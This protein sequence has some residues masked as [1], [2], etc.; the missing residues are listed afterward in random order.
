[1]STASPMAAPTGPHLDPASYFGIYSDYPYTKRE[2]KDSS[3]VSVVY[4]VLLYR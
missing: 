2:Q 4:S 1:M 3:S